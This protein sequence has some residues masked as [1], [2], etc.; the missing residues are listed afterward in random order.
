MP[1]VPRIPKN[2]RQ[3]ISFSL[4]GTQSTAK[5]ALHHQ[6]SLIG[7]SFIISLPISYRCNQPLAAT[8]A[9]LDA[10]RSPTLI[11]RFQQSADVPPRCSLSGLRRKADQYHEEVRSVPGRFDN[12]VST[13]SDDAPDSNKQLEQQSRRISFAGRLDAVNNLTRKPMEGRWCQR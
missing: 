7:H 2:D 1:G 10:V 6:Q 3:N 8:Q 12:G 5:F 9:G 4:H 13:T 11:D